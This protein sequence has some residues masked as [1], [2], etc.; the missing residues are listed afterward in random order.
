MSSKG[1][2]KD[3]FHSIK[4][5]HI[6]FKQSW[7]YFRSI[8]KVVLNTCQAPSWQWV[9]ED[10]WTYVH[11]AHAFL[12]LE[13]KVCIHSFIHSFD[14]CLVG[15]YHEPGTVVKTRANNLMEHMCKWVHK[16]KL[17]IKHAATPIGRVM[18]KRTLSENYGNL[19]KGGEIEL[20]LERWIRISER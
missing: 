13:R 3:S 2:S 14:K 16:C 15:A 7:M 8:W 10:S 20:Y 6:S 19:H 9:F 12:S 17:Q 11:H 4:V 5:I 18:H 1:F